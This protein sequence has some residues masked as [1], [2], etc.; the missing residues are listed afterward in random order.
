MLLLL[1]LLLSLHQLKVAQMGRCHQI[2]ASN[3]LLLNQVAEHTTITLPNREIA[4]LMCMLLCYV[5]VLIVLHNGDRFSDRST[6]RSLFFY[7]ATLR[8]NKSIDE[9]KSRSTI[10]ATLIRRANGERER[11][12]FLPNF[13]CS[14]V[15][16]HLRNHLCSDSRTIL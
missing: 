16:R 8:P 14:K 6:K 2:S 3:S 11:R 10:L 1:L 7:L 13:T 5:S 15:Q 4:R 12:K 9:A